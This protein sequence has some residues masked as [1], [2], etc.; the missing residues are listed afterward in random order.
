[1]K[2]DRHLITQINIQHKT[3]FKKNTTASFSNDL[4]SECR[5]IMH[6]IL[7]LNAKVGKICAQY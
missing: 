5:N 1:M 7:V 4:F 2:N 3:E 6:K